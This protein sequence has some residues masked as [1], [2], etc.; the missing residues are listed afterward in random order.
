MNRSIDVRPLLGQLDLPTLVV[1]RTGDRSNP[2]E[3]GRYLA[4]TIP[5]A[6]LAELP[7]DDHLPWLGDQDALFAVIQEF[8]T[9]SLDTRR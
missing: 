4:A 5:G 6:V 3:L 7:G 1:H 8:L 2:I 9:G